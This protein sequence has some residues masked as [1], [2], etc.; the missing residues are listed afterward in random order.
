[1]IPRPPMNIRSKGQRS[2]HRVTKCITS[3][4][5]S[6]A[7]PSCCGGVVTQ[8]DGAARPSRRATTQPSYSRRS[9]GRRQLCTLSSAQPSLIILFVGQTFAVF[10]LLTDQP[11][12]TV[13]Y[14]I[15]CAWFI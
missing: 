7:A 12:C 2:G 10:R 4:R 15:L 8:R 1:M 11:L 5:D 14:P 9:S 13:S 6:R 3:R